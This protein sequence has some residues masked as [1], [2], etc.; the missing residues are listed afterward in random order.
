MSNE[1]ETPK[2]RANDP[3]RKPDDF[4][5]ALGLSEEDQAGMLKKAENKMWTPTWGP[6]LFDIT[7]CRDCTG[8]LRYHDDTCPRLRDVIHAVTD[9]ETDKANEERRFTD[10]YTDETAEEDNNE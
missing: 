4:L 9:P 2:D 1:P 8:S 5:A 10:L 6:N 3:N 7:P